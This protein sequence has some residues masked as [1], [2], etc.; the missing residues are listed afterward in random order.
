LPDVPVVAVFDTSFHQT[1]PEVAALYALPLELAREKGLRRYGF[2]GISHRYVASR[3]RERLGPKTGPSRL[4]TCHL[5]NGA[6][7]CA[8]RDGKSIDTSMGL[9]PLEGL[10]MG[11]RSGDVDPGLILHLLHAEAFSPDELD[12]LLNQRS[13]LLG[14]GGH[15]DVRDLKKAAEAG[16]SRAALALDAF[17]YR[18]RKYIGA[19]AAVL[20]GLDGIAFTAGIGENSALVREKI[21][22]GLA[23]LGARLDRARNEQPGSGEACISAAGSPVALWVIPTDEETQIARET[24][25]VVAGRE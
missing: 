5:G 8:V 23:W 9:T 17:A 15:A 14:L 19:Y 3:L 21:C 7:L 2:H 13:G 20:E 25:G 22:T 24:A 6:S 18:V 12:R 4:I 1:M 16:D 11:T 10:V